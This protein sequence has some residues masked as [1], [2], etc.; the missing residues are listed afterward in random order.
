MKI[1]LI[2]STGLVGRVILK[3]LEERN[4]PIKKFYPV[5]SNKSKGKKIFF[6]G[7]FYNLLNINQSL[8]YK[9]DLAL[10]SSGENI[11][12]KWAEK[13]SKLGTIV[14]DN[15]SAWRMDPTK[16]LI[17]PEVNANKISKSDK[18]ISN[19]NCSTIQLVMTLYPLHKE[20][21]IKRIIVSTYQSV[22]GSGKKGIYQL[23]KEMKG[24]KSNKAYP[25][26][27]YKN[28]LPHCDKFE[29]NLYTKEEMKLINETK[30]IMNDYTIS[31]T[32]TCARV[33]VIG[34]HSESVHVSFKKDFNINDIKKILSNSPGI[35]IQDNPKKN[36]YPMPINS[37]NKNEVF[38]GRIRK[39]ISQKKS[40][41]L[42]I[43]SDNLRKGAATNAIQIAEYLLRKKILK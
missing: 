35:I 14:I 18:I 31:I 43:V 30:K 7:K 39:D 8:I 20:Y 29:K 42:W 23:K 1:A 3:I 6:K 34:G 40:L 4:F 27:I 37:Y 16:K 25:Y 10:F 24:K 13:F 33:P 41:H 15:S 21:I 28:V 22:T 26:P 12:K 36:I 11:S 32:A 19:P 38:V 5:S 9:P 17:I 2:G